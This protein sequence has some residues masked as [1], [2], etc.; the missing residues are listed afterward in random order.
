MNKCHKN[1]IINML[2]NIGSNYSIEYECINGIKLI[3]KIVINHVSLIPAKPRIINVTCK[4]NN[5]EQCV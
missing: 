2:E 5:Q 4:I 3:K 1:P